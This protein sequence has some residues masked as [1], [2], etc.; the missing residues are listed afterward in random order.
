MAI[1]QF[2]LWMLCRALD[3][4]EAFEKFDVA[5]LKHSYIA[6]SQISKTWLITGAGGF[7]VHSW[8]FD[9]SGLV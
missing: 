7:L 9:I 3:M 5:E 2:L 1:Y 6:V 4:L 8:S